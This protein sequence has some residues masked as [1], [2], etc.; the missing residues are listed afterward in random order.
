M[1]IK[2]VRVLGRVDFKCIEDTGSYQ[3]R[4]VPI[5]YLIAFA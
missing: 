4:I 1:G 5:G 3:Q 2:Y